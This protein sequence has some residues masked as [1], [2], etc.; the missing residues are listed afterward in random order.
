MTNVGLSVRTDHHRRNRIRGCARASAS[1]NLQARR[2][3]RTLGAPGNSDVRRAVRKGLGKEQENSLK[4]RMLKRAPSVWSQNQ[5]V[6]Q[7]LIKAGYDGAVAP[8]AYSMMRLVSLI[9]LPLLVFLFM[10][11]DTFAKVVMAVAMAAVMGLLIPPFVL[12]RL[13]AARKEKIQTVASRCA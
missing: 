9:G 3:R 1:R 7:R 11:S 12:L 6:Q 5:T 8:L 10:P 13:E 2:S 4:A